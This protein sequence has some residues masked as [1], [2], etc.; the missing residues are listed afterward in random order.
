MRNCE[1][2]GAAMPRQAMFCPS[3]GRKPGSPSQVFTSDMSLAPEQLTV[4]VDPRTQTMA[5]SSL[6][7][8]GREHQQADAPTLIQAG[9][10][11]RQEEEEEEE[12]RQEGMLLFPF[13]GQGAA[14][15]GAPLVQ[16]TP[17]LG[18]A[19]SLPGRP[20][21]GGKPSPEPA[22]AGAPTARLP[23]NGLPGQPIPPF[24]PPISLPPALPVPLPQP[25]ITV[26][27]PAPRPG[28]RPTPQPPVGCNVW[29]IVVLLPLLILASLFGVGM[30]VL[31]PDIS[32]TMNGSNGN[33]IAIG[34]QFDLHGSKF[35]PGSTVTLLLDNAP[36]SL[37]PGSSS[38]RQS[39]QPLLGAQVQAG[40]GLMATNTIT[41]SSNGTFS[42]PIHVG[43]DWRPGL[44]T[45]QA[46][47]NLSPR[48]AHLTFTVYQSGTDVTP[49]PT[50]TATVP[51]T[52]TPT[53]TPTATI[54][55]T[56]GTQPSVLS[57]VTPN[58]LNL[59]PVSE[60]STRTVT[61]QLT[62]NTSGP[63]QVN[64]LAS[65]DTAGA[66][67]LTLDQSSGQIQAPASQKITLS[68]NASSLKAGNYSATVNFS[69][70][71]N[72]QTLGLS[73]SFTVLRGCI[74]ANP[75]TL[76]FSG[77]AGLSDPAPQRVVINNCGRLAGAWSMADPNT[78]W[79]SV[80]PTSG[81]LNGGDTQTVTVSVS[82]IKAK[83]QPGPYQA[84]LQFSNGSSQVQVQVSLTVLAPPQLQVSSPTLDANSTSCSYVLNVNKQYEWVCDEI[85]SNA[86]NPAVSINWSASSTGVPGITFTDA[87]NAPYASGTLDPGKRTL[88]RIHVP[89][90]NCQ[91]ATSIIFTGPGNTVTVP[92][93]CVIIG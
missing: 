23:Q 1:F 28:S 72:P 51:P 17:H 45:L 83:L 62:L 77:V 8:P 80:S 10:I 61:A 40:L 50:V 43:T 54:T 53:A 60:D 30:T 63:G 59:G 79:L 86:G 48:S 26:G 12:K 57:S 71:G 19:P 67:W 16:G 20:H 81:T 85:L 5:T 75:G 87:N 58:I 78:N 91:T 56:I 15:G 69:N 74:G 49:G 65:W 52:V 35:I 37:T 92:W 68:A 18:G 84:T 76:N 66:S 27:P 55:P 89:Q 11:T 64:W 70:T 93:T 73:V 3:C 25:P 47:E 33:T 42:V 22:G 9:L 82:N 38:A 32:I 41:T 7:T 6:A 90:N 2:C 24:V 4:L 36:L 44:H 14:P 46:S 29:L 31:A 21:L 39:I 88:V 13:P 34:S